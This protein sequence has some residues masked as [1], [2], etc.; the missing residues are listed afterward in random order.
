MSESGL[1]AGSPDPEAVTEKSC[2]AG[3]EEMDRDQSLPGHGRT[4]ISSSTLRASA[5]IAEELSYGSKLKMGIDADDSGNR[6]AEGSLRLRMVI[7][8]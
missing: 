2:R 6:L 4:G 5:V 8:L 3:A 7:E 1:I